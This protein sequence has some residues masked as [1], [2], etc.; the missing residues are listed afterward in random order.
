METQKMD[1]NE[2]NNVDETTMNEFLRDEELNAKPR[3]RRA[4]RPKGSLNRRVLVKEVIRYFGSSDIKF[5]N[6]DIE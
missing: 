1:N 2:K 3:K 6:E 4:G 5:R